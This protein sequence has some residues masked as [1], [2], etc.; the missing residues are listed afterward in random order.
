[1]IR[2]RPTVL[3]HRLSIF[4]Y[5]PP[6]ADPILEQAH[7]S[8][9]TKYPE[10]RTPKQ[11]EPC[12]CF[13]EVLNGIFMESPCPRC[14]FPTPIEFNQYQQSNPTISLQKPSI[15]IPPNANYRQALEI[16]EW[17]HQ[18][19]RREIAMHSL[20]FKTRWVCLLHC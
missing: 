4:N 2:I 12:S 6:I 19:N 7:V 13:I 14:L 5:L 20:L 17:A 16:D 1:M 18:R 9:Q 3:Y 10:I 11:S 15:E 8:S